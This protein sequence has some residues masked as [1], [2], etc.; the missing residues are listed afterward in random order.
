[1]QMKLSDFA[2]KIFFEEICEFMYAP[3][4]HKLS[5]LILFKSPLHAHPHRP[6][7]TQVEKRTRIYEGRLT[8]DNNS[9][10]RCFLRHI[11]S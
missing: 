6:Q 7:T 11:I 4:L 2:E 3:S 1:M 8:A 5:E 9:S 10:V